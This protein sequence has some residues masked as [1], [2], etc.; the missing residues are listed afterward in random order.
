VGF[1]GFLVGPP[2][3]GVIAGAVSLRLSFTLI[4]LMGLLIAVLIFNSRQKGEN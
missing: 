2:V 3:I 1:L 4:A